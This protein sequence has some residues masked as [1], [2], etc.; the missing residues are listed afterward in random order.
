MMLHPICATNQ[1]P[2]SYEFH[3]PRSSDQLS[4]ELS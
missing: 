1:V 2:V 3:V 4:R